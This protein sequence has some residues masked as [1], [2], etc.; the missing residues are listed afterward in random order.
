MILCN[1]L[2]ETEHKYWLVC[3]HH[4]E[5]HVMSCHDDEIFLKFVVDTKDS[6]NYIYVSDFLNVEYDELT[7]DSLED[8]LDQ[9]EDLVTDHIN[10]K[11][12]YYKDMLCNFTA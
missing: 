8:A 9:F 10:E 12:S 1:K 3:E 4:Y 11:I 5:L 7:A 2:R 6:K